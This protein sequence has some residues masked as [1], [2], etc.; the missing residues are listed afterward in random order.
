MHIKLGTD[1]LAAGC[2]ARQ[3]P[4]GRRRR[5]RRQEGRTARRW[6]YRRAIAGLFQGDDYIHMFKR[7]KSTATS[8]TPPTAWPIAPI[9]CTTSWSRCA[10]PPPAATFGQR[11]ARPASRG[12]ATT[13]LPGAAA[14]QGGD[15]RLPHTSNWDFLFGM[16]GRFALGLDVRWV[17][18]DS[19]FCWPVAGLLAWG[20]I[21]VNRRQPEGFVDQMAAASP[22]ARPSP[23]HC[24]G[25]HPQPH[26]RLEN[27]LLPHRP[28]AGVPS[29]W[30]PSTT[31]GARSA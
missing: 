26:P 5:R 15:R 29:S 9:R 31:G 25:R 12:W 3:P 11:L 6:A 16:L 4:G 20:G 30:P 1:A 2:Q 8:P 13:R 21:P 7:R 10:D 14:G 22:T 19:L 24:A 17:G 27:G 28:G 18:K 23:R